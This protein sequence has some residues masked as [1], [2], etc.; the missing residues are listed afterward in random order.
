V[1]GGRQPGDDGLR[2]ADSLGY[3]FAAHQAQR[4]LQ[5]NLCRPSTVGRG[6]GGQ[7]LFL[8]NRGLLHIDLTVTAQLLQN[9]PI[10]G[11]PESDTPLVSVM[12]HSPDYGPDHP[13]EEYP[14]CFDGELAQA[15]GRMLLNAGRL[16]ALPSVVQSG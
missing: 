6:I 16:A 5:L 3:V 4:P 13:A 9:L 2:V 1:L 15:V 7:G 8:S 10:D 11:Y 14:F 12:M